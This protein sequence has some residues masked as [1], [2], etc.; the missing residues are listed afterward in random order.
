MRDGGGTDVAV[1]GHGIVAQSHTQS[2][3]SYH[4]T[5]GFFVKMPWYQ[6]L[7]AAGSGVCPAEYIS[8]GA[9]VQ[10]CT[11]CRPGTPAGMSVLLPLPQEFVLLPHPKDAA[12]GE[13]INTS[14]TCM[15]H[16]A[17]ASCSHALQPLPEAS[18]SEASLLPSL[19]APTFPPLSTAVFVKRIACL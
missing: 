15:V 11:P 13:T 1:P 6:H 2:A 8:P 9:G 5:N 19:P 4:S 3:C 17:Q 7:P 16:P 18:A 10:I 12:L 14:P